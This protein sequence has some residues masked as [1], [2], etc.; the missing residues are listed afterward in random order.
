[1]TV[2]EIR[3]GRAAGRA[4]APPSKSYTHRA[5][6][7]GYLTGRQYRV[8]DPLDSD[9]TRATL[10]GIRHL[11][12]T[13]RESKRRWTVSPPIAPSRRPVRIDCRQSGTTL[14]LLAAVAAR[15]ARPVTFVGDVQLGRRPMD[16]LVA[17]LARRGATVQAPARG[18]LPLTVRGPLSGGP[19][20]VDGSVSSQFVSAMLLV[21]PTV[22]RPSTLR[23]IGT[24]V[25]RP[26]VEAT[27]AVLRAHGVALKGGGRLWRIAA[28]QTY[29]SRHFR[30]PGDA[31]SAAYLWAAAA[32]SGGQVRV[33]NVDPRWPQADRRLLAVLR[34][35]GARVAERGSSVTVSGRANR[36]FEAE[37][38]DAPDLYP[39]LGALAATI[40]AR[41]RL[42]GAPHILHKE[43]N[44][45]VSTTRLA[46][47][48]GARV[49]STRRGLEILGASRVRPLDLTGLDDHRLV[50]S[51][52]V[53]ALAADSPSRIADAACVGKSFPGFWLA[54]RDLGVEVKVGP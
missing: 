52:A 28:P 31:S 33:E 47:A 23:V 22:D 26:Y 46:R 14:R 44:R 12:R 43:S 6:I 53:G 24:Q 11:G 1:M 7:A 49:R 5:L 13:V 37:L 39:L 10:D 29:R 16:G 42:L 30:V 54:L 15:E 34:A 32:T 17:A 4:R 48:L 45:R 3:P 40:P 19:S 25:S 38:T 20:V 18:S 2:A 36:G 8:D 27:V 50:M 9:D 51:A 21:L 41:S 35:A